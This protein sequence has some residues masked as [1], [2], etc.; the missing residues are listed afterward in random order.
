[1]RDFRRETDSVTTT[2]NAAYWGIR[3][4]A[5]VALLWCTGLV[6]GFRTALLA[7][8]IV[9]LLLAAVGIFHSSI[10]V[11]AVAYLACLDSVA[12]MYLIDAGFFRWNTLNYP[13]LL[14]LFV[15]LPAILKKND[16]HTALLLLFVALLLGGLIV[17]P[18]LENGV[19]HIL[20]V[21][22]SFG[23]LACFVRARNEPDLWTWVALVNGVAVAIGGLVFYFDAHVEKLNPNGW[24][25]FPLAGIFS[26]CLASLQASRASL[27]PVLVFLAAVA[28]GWTMLSGSRGSTLVAAVCLLFLLGA[29]RR[30]ARRAAYVAICVLMCAALA[31]WFIA[32]STGALKRLEYT[33]DSTQSFTGRSSGRWDLIVAGWEIFLDHPLGV[34]TGGYSSSFLELDDAHLAFRGDY[35]QAHAG[36]IKILTENGIAGVLTFVAYVLSFAIY[37][38]RERRH[39]WLALGLLTTTVLA[40]YFVF[41]E[42]QGKCVWLLAAGAAA[43]MHARSERMIDA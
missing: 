4:T 28:F 16:I 40:A 3:L 25:L 7:N 13:L 31:A 36:W 9:A 14:L 11:F 43:A 17:S 39:G 6:V 37:G 35:R 41:S 15:C 32:S 10:A 42:F 27:R 12:R 33:L 23:L 1:M 34:G 38:W 5:L 22:A 30:L 2:S 8:V 26:I 20:N 19:Q 21:V 18:D 29:E 24:A